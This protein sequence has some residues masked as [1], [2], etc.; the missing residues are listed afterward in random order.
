MSVKDYIEK[1][2][3]DERFGVRKFE[4]PSPDDNE[5]RRYDG[6]GQ[7]KL[8]VG[9]LKSLTSLTLDNLLL[10]VDEDFYLYP[11]N[12]VELNRPFEWIELIQPETRLN[13]NSRIQ[14][15]VPYIFEVA[16]RNVVLVGKWR[17]SDAVPSDIKLAATKLVAGVIKEN[18]N[19][20]DV[21]ELKS[22]KVGD[23]TVNYQ[24]ITK[25]AHALKVDEILNQYK[26]KVVTTTAGIRKI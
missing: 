12:S 2:C 14:S 15:S 20:E 8:N 25:V 19:D 26:R 1:F 3:G 16:Q 11:L 9:D 23:Y 7:I 18:I 21:R 6:N 22:E 17:Y 10:V 24:D 13:V 5:T 4:K